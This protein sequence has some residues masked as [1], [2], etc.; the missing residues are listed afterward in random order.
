[1]RIQRCKKLAGAGKP[2]DS[3]KEVLEKGKSC[4]IR[5]ERDVLGGSGVE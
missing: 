5:P 3:I 1:M 4:E 2:L